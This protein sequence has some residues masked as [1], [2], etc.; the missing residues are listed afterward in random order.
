MAKPTKSEYIRWVK[1]SLNRLLGASLADDANIFPDYRSWLIT[2]QMKQ[3]L[4]VHAQVDRPTQDALIKANRKHAGYVRW[5]QTALL[6]SGEGVKTKG[7]PIVADGIWGAHTEQAV[8]DFQAMHEKVKAD[9][10]VGANTE[11]LL[12]LRTGTVPPGRTKVL[13]DPKPDPVVPIWDIPVPDDPIPEFIE[14]GYRFKTSEGVS[15]SLSKGGVTAGVLHLEETSNRTVMKLNYAAIGVGLSP[16]PAAAERSTTDM[17]SVGS[18]IRNRL[19]GRDALTLNDITGFCLIYQGVFVSGV[20]PGGYGTIM[21][22]SVGSG[23]VY[24][25]GATVL[26]GGYGVVAVPAIVASSCHSMVGM[27]GINNGSPNVGVSGAIGYLGFGDVGEKID[28]L[29]GLVDA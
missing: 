11:R 16:I 9:G 26:T 15:I 20:N 19:Y 21:L 13:R 14:F 17:P 22:L 2:F 24:A 25:Y 27:I 8:K 29:K 4:V 5:I 18:I 10:W 1:G 28:K 3:K 6:I 23:L 12:M 7:K